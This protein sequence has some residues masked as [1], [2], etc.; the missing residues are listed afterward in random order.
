MGEFIILLYVEFYDAEL[1][2]ARILH[3]AELSPSSSVRTWPH[4]RAAGKRVV[5]DPWNRLINPNTCTCH[6]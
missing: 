5:G 6:A 4:E 3:A 1:N 2:S